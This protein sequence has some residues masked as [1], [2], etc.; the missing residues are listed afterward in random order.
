MGS[1]RRELSL[2]VTTSRRHNSSRRCNQSFIQM[3]T[4]QTPAGQI[5]DRSQPDQ[6]TT[7]TA[8]NNGL[9]QRI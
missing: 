3:A 8:C 6:D 1:R 7:T 5:L 4:W 2:S 9:E